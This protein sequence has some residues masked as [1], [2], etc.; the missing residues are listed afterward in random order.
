MASNSPEF[1]KTKFS[2]R[3][4]LVYLLTSDQ[5]PIVVIPRNINKVTWENG[6]C[7]RFNARFRDKLLNGE[8]F[9]N[10]RE[11]QIIIQKWR[12]SYI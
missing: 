4:V 6:Y 5:N 9:C 8:I 2:P 10:L 7:E 1:K 12:R 11:A 3:F